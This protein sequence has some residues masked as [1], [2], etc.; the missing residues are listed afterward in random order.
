[1]NIIINK[2]TEPEVFQ[3]IENHKNWNEKQL[4]RLLAYVEKINE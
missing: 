3:I 4:K 2:N 1:M